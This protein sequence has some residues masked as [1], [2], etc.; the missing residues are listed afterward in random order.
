VTGS[1]AAIRAELDR[2]GEDGGRIPFWWRDDDAIRHTPALDE[3]L[4]LASDVGTPLA[5]AAVPAL[6]EPSLAER[7]SDE[8]SVAVLVH[9]RA[10]RNHAP[11]GE[12]SA[13]FG[14]HR[15]LDVMADEAGRA[16]ALTRSLFGRQ[17]IPIFVPPW[18]RIE[19]ALVP[20]LDEAGYRAYSTFGG[21]FD[22][23]DGVARLDTHLDPVDWRGTRGLLREDALA[24][25][26]TRALAATRDGRAG[27]IG[28]LA[29]HLVFDRGLWRFCAGLL[30][31]L[32][33]HSAVQWVGAEA[34]V[35]D[36]PQ[37]PAIARPLPRVMAPTA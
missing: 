36:G 32:G 33:R 14:P 7:L 24:A 26:F 19:P 23:R 6:T 31:L 5:L 21:G 13:E 27:P 28:L 3:L 29:H 10:H 22:L 30:D 25:M 35:E 4:A 37:R 2:V 1:L 16:L 15:P 12:K 8:P 11:A 34:L 9:G 17:A 18:N 20:L